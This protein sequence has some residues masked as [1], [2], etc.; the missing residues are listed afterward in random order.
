MRF[1]GEGF[2]MPDTDFRSDRSNP[3][4]SSTFDIE[5]TFGAPPTKTAFDETYDFLFTIQQ[6]SMVLV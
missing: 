6:K 4:D 2:Q 3:D 1:G 5:A